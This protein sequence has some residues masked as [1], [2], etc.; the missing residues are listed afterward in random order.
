M[1][2]RFIKT[3]E[4]ARRDQNDHFYR[5]LIGGLQNAIDEYSYKIVCE[6]RSILEIETYSLAEMEMHKEESTRWSE[7]FDVDLNRTEIDI[8]M[9]TAELEGMK[10]KYENTVQSIEFRG[11]EM[12]DF[13]A[14]KEERA[15]QKDSNLMKLI[16]N[17]KE[18]LLAKCHIISELIWFLTMNCKLEWISV[19]NRT[20]KLMQHLHGKNKFLFDTNCP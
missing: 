3:W 7:K 9:S 1:E 16:N 13:V 11:Q 12:V 20:I 14:L 6:S 18:R 19:Q 17:H 2:N 5:L 15:L 8:Q 10:M 4:K